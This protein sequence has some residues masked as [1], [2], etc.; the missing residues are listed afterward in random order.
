MVVVIRNGQETPLEESRE[1]L[2][3]VV[4]LVNGIV[5][6]DMMFGPSYL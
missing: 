5:V 6:R 2:A 3:L 4:R 1:K